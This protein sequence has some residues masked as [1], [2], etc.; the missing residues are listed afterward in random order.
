MCWNNN[1]GGP[2]APVYAPADG[3]VVAVVNTMGNT[4]GTSDHGWGNLVKI[5]HGNNVYTLMAHLKK[6][7]VSVKVGQLVKRG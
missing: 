3:T 7:S 2:N 4:W 5:S 1:Y 6:G